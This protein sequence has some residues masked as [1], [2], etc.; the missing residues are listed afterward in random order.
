MIMKKVSLRVRVYHI[1]SAT[2]EPSLATDW[3][4][5]TA[6]YLLWGSYIGM[7]QCTA[8]NTGRFQAI[9][10]NSAPEGSSNKLIV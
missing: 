4:R 5:S 10:H 2:A 6:S 9:V 8:G 3:Q 7:A 1:Y